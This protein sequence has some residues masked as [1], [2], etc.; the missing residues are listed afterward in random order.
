M[1]SDAAHHTLESNTRPWLLALGGWLICI[2][3]FFWPVVFQGKVLAPLD[4]LDSL[5]KPWATSETIDVHNA[6]T[7]DAISQYLPY[8]WSVYQSL[9]QDGY[10]GWNPYAHNGTAILENTMLCPGDWHHQLYRVLPFWDAWDTGII[11]Q[12]A[13]AGI[14]MLVL[15]RFLGIPAAFALVGIVGFGFYSQ[16]TLWI[17]HRWVI[18]SMCWAPWITW[19]LLRAKQKKRWIDPLPIVFIAL[20]FRGGHLQACLFIVLLVLLLFTTESSHFVNKQH[21]FFK[22]LC[23]YA[24]SGI[25][26]T[27]LCADVWINTIPPYL[28][29][30]K[31]MPISGFRHCILSASILVT[32]VLPTILGTPNGLDPSK[33]LETSLFDVQFMGAT[34]FLLAVLGLFRKKAPAAAKSL[35]IVGLIIP[36]TPLDTWLYSRVT[37]IYALGGAWL[38]SWYLAVAAEEPFHRKLWKRIA[39]LFCLMLAA[40]LVASLILAY[41]RPHLEPSLQDYIVSL[42]PANKS[43]RAEWM[44]QRTSIFID[45]SYLW[46][47]F[48]LAVLTLIGLGLFLA[49]RVHKA[50]PRCAWYA[51]GIAACTFGELF[52]FSRTWI[53]FS[54][55][56]S[57]DQALYNAPAWVE[58]LKK[59]AGNGSVSCYSQKR[60]DYMQLNTPSSYGIR[61]QYGYETV[62]PLHCEPLDKSAYIPEDYAQAGVS[63]FFVYDDTTPTNLIEKGWISV[64]ESKDF[65]LYKN[66]AFS[67][68]INALLHDGT[69]PPIQISSETP[70]TRIFTIP[71]GTVA[72]TIG[73][74][75]HPGWNAHLGDTVLSIQ[76]NIRSGMQVNL[77]GPTDGPAEVSMQFTPCFSIFQK[78]KI[79]VGAEK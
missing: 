21:D 67:S 72:V 24:C 66:P 37:T 20:G 59:A 65:K 9:R 36:F 19:A 60:F 31:G 26:A 1:S 62:Q 61:F 70:N 23:L 38:G 12:F 29:G 3:L 52:L 68:R 50:N 2:A 17:Y 51:I 47:T 40:W 57:S 44:R 49:S 48:N 35:F 15:F 58:T 63:L 45:R 11:L 76:K 13:I 16:F 73:E 41:I 46:N 79:R 43:N 30:G 64:H 39:T 22:L 54:K 10:I 8:D 32:T 56:P 27:L 25:I 78:A 4:I 75:Y 74:T 7:Y 42:L 28:G 18:G 53:T 55:H 34:L 33:S 69:T 5:L 71:S 77:P 6:F 14:G